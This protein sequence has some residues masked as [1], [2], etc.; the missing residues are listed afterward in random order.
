MTDLTLMWKALATHQPIADK[1]GYGTEWKQMC[2]EKTSDAIDAA[3]SAADAAAWD[4]A[5][6]ALAAAADAAAWA[7]AAAKHMQR[8]IKYTTEANKEMSE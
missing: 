6:A 1:R 8:A 5:D 2:A 3:W 7:V 4:A